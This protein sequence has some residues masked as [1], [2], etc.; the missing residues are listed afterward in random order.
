MRNARPCPTPQ[1]RRDDPYHNFLLALFAI[2][3]NLC[4]RLL[5]AGIQML[6]KFFYV[7]AFSAAACFTAT[8]QSPSLSPA[9][10]AKVSLADIA[11]EWTY[12]SFHNRP[13]TVDD[14]AEKALALIFAE[15]TMSF[16]APSG[17]TLK[18]KIDWPGG[19]LDMQGAIRPGVEADSFVIDVVGAGRP[20]TSTAGWEYDYFAQLAHR[21]P[22]GV[23]QRPALVGSVLRAKPH[24]S[25]AAGYV[26]SFIAVKRP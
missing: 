8:A 13:E 24:G 10:S 2:C 6:R 12:R 4:V 11:G 17:S 26:A 7:A 14:D 19:G 23:N 9:H 25:S 5:T 18:G 1:L 15:A 3:A 22:T 21:W 16:E 20:G